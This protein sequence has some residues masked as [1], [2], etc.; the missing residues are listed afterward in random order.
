MGDSSPA[1]TRIT[2]CPH[3][4]KDVSPT[5]VTDRDG[6]LVEVNTA[7]RQ[8]LNVSQQGV[9][10]RAQMWALFFEGHRDRVF[11]AQAS[12]TPDPSPP[13]GAVLRPRER[14]PRRIYTHVRE[15]PDGFLEWTIH[16]VQQ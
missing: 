16:P 15:L 1:V 13:F 8:I 14:A 12:A 3:C 6:L 11:H 7:A 4:G 5:I 10:R 9:E 2:S